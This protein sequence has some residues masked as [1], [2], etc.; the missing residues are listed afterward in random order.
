MTK[1]GVLV[2]AVRTSLVVFVLVV[3]VSQLIFANEGAGGSVNKRCLTT[4]HRSMRR[5]S[6]YF[7]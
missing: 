2:S 1:L 7:F 4:K 3:P 6:K 5:C